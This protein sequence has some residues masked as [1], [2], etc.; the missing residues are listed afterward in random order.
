MFVLQLTCRFP[1]RKQLVCAAISQNILRA[2]IFDGVKSVHL[3]AFG[4][5]KNRCKIY[6]LTLLLTTVGGRTA[7]LDL[8]L[9]IG[10]YMVKGSTQ[11]VNPLS[12]WLALQ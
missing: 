9:A 8:L 10:H 2:Q 6:L 1:S 12:E 4:I 3:F 11:L 5:K 7:S